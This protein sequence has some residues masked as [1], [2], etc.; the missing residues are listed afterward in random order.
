[1]T[2]A[3]GCNRITTNIEHTITKM[4]VTVLVRER[5]FMIWGAEEIKKNSPGKN[6]YTEGVLRSRDPP[7]SPLNHY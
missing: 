6:I 7:C 4:N 3:L 1:M 5:P 2:L